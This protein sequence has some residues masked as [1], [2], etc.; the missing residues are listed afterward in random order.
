MEGKKEGRIYIFVDEGMNGGE[1]KHWRPECLK[2][3]RKKCLV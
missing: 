1:T 3:R 2:R